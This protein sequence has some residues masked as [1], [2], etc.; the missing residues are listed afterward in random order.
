MSKKIR[1]TVIGNGYN[2]LDGWTWQDG[3]KEFFIGSDEFAE[4]LERDSIWAIR[5]ESLSSAWVTRVYHD[6]TLRSDL[7]LDVQMT[8]RKETK[9]GRNYWYAYRRKGGKLQKRYVGQSN[10]VNERRIVEIAEHML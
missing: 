3:E 9:S 2:V 7:E 6:A 10:A 1:Q 8:L 4:F 5:I